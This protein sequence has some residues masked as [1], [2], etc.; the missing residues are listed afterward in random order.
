MSDEVIETLWRIKDDIAREY[1]YDVA[2]LAAA[3]RA[4]QGNASHRIVDLQAQR[5]LAQPP[6]PGM[7]RTGF[8]KVACSRE[9]SQGGSPT[10]GIQKPGSRGGVR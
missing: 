10:P 9:P 2:R 5:E 6:M 3:L 7:N 4:E 1:G 8:P